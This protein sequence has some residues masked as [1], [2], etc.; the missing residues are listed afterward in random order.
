[1]NLLSQELHKQWLIFDEKNLILNGETRKF[2]PAPVAQIMT[3]FWRKTL[4][5]NSKTRK[6]ALEPVAQRMTDFWRKTLILNG[7]TRKLYSAR[8]A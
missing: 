7:K 6:F 3:K 8:V 2:A 4:I 5:L 1:M